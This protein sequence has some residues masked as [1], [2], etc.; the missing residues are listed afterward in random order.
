MRAHFAIFLGKIISLLSRFL[1]IG[2]GSAAPGL[3]ALRIDPELVEGLS[4][5]I[6]RNVI[7]TGT[8]G[9]TTT[10]RIL[11][12]LAK[13]AGLKVIRNSTGSNLERGIASALISW[14]PLGVNVIHPPGG[15]ASHLGIWELD[16]FAF[17]EVALKIKPDIVVFLNVFRDQLD[18]YGEV[19]T[20]VK[21]WCNTLK[22]LSKETTILVNGDDT[23]TLKLA[24]CFKGKVE[25]FGV[26]DYKIKGES[27]QK[28][29]HHKLDFEAKNVRLKGLEGSSFEFSFPIS[30]F[31]FHLP[32]PGIYHIYDGVAALTAAHHLNLPV[33]K[34]IKS[35][36]NSNPLS[37]EWKNFPL[38][39][40]SLLKILPGLLRFL[41][42]LPHR[43]NLMTG[44]L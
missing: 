44:F 43:L 24:E 2:G 41:K 26:E 12:H 15:L 1:K 9:K 37:V 31:S 30:H 33:N 5:H 10:A 21:R 17:N 14:Y 36:N 11:A 8:N 22:A 18:R 42:Q 28:S 6:P 3:F 7:I 35:L 27:L 29:T 40:F 16:E 4:R 25:T 38:D 20:V 34:L 13:E 23:N 32:I 39:I 19:D